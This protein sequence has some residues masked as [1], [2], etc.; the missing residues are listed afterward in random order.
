MG[1]WKDQRICKPFSKD[2]FFVDFTL[3]ERE[4][5]RV[6]SLQPF[7]NIF[8]APKAFR[9]IVVG[10]AQRTTNVEKKEEGRKEKMRAN[11][12][13]YFSKSK[14]FKSCIINSKNSK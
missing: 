13:F 12:Y 6:E 14:K 10:L 5:G 8:I 3:T 4:W 1:P 2:R 11:F 9:L 7:V